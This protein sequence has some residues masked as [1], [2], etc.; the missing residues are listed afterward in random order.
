MD[1]NNDT[2]YVS[3]DDFLGQRES[4]KRD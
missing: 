2:S 1:F 3:P 4:V